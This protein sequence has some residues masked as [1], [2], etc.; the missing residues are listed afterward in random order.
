MLFSFIKLL[1]EQSTILCI[2][3]VCVLE[4]VLHMALLLFTIL[5]TITMRYPGDIDLHSLLTPGCW[6]TYCPLLT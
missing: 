6:R 2:Y 5:S 3:P 1:R 4:Y